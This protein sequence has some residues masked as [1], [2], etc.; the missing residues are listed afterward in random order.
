ME[1]GVDGSVNLNVSIAVTGLLRKSSPLD[2]MAAVLAVNNF[3]CIFER[4]F[5]EYSNFPEICS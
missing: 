1:P 5:A 2:K 3:K 4:K